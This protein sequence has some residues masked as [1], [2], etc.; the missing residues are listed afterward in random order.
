MKDIFSYAD[1]LGPHKVVHVNVP[2]IGLKG[3]LVVDN[4]A[5]G[6][7]IGGLRIATDV[8]TEECVRLARAMT[9]KNAAAGIAYGG[10]K[11]VICGDPN[12]D[13]EKK[14]L[15]LRGFCRSLEEIDDYIFAPDMGTNEEC[16][17]WIKD[18][19]GRVVGLPR[20]VGGIPLDEIGATGY[21]ISQVA[22]VAVKY[23]DFDLKGA[24]VV[25]QG[26]GS[27]GKNAAKF[28]QEK[29]AVIVGVADSKGSVFDADGLDVNVLTQLKNAGKSVKDYKNY[30]EGKTLDRDSVI[31]M[32]CDIWIPAARPDIINE[33]NV[34]RLK[35]KLIISGAN[36]P[37]TAEAETILHK[38]GILNVPDFIAN[39][40][41]VIC[42][43]MEYEGANEAKVFEV[44]KNKLLRNTE[45]VLKESKKENILP[46][47][48]ALRLATERVT[49]AMSLKRWSI[50]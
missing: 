30:N 38:K 29:G 36:I 19:I 26:F 33:D 5:K 21:G 25:I 39:A 47:E 48:A 14:E 11:T 23:C 42:A 6:P 28:L 32:E 22:E 15:L 50:F 9:M 20:E 17:G 7:A 45:L 35:A 31:D 16:M 46:R 3:I 1:E 24:R 41:G 37:I 40:G 12:M 27:V 49:K 4:V 34:E 43:A 44:I 2:S 8:T 18:E 10:G 13:K